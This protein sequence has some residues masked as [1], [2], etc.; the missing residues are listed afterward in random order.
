MHK[1]NFA[2][3]RFIEELSDSVLMDGVHKGDQRAFEALFRRYYRQVYGAAYRQ[4]GSHDQA[5]DL[6][7]EAFLKLHQHPLSNGKALNVGGWLYRVVTNLGYNALRTRSRQES[8]R[9]RAEEVAEH[10]G[11]MLA[12]EGDPAEMVA[13]HEDQR[14]VRRALAYLPQREQ[15]CLILRGQGLSYAEIAAV[16]EVAPGSVGTILARAVSD[17]KHR[18]LALLEG[19]PQND[20]P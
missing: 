7:Q 1:Q 20:L 16:L 18:Y 14:L 9:R 13:R 3:D 12:T 8:R 4:V 5:E 10:E 2:D 19:V 15:A 11:P 17:L 6:V